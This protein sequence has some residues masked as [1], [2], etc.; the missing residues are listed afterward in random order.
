MICESGAA[1]ASQWDVR[2]GPGTDWGL[3]CYRGEVFIEVTT[4]DVVL[5]LSRPLQ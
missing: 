3:R 5:A 2:P 1:H 4:P